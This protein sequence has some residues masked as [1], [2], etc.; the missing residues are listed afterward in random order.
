MKKGQEGDIRRTHEGEEFA[1]LDDAIDVIEDGLGAS[2]L[3]ILDGDG[4]A[5]P[6]KAADVGVGELGVVT[7][8]HLL[9][10]RHLA[11]AAAIKRAGLIVRHFEGSGWFRDGAAVDE[12]GRRERMEAG[13]SECRPRGG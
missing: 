13:E 3:A 10:V 5:L 12:G 8:D 4:D 9:D 2:G 11:V 1:G 6:A 7:A